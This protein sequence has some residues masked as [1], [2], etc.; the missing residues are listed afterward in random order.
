MFHFKHFMAPVLQRMRICY[1]SLCI[2]NYSEVWTVGLNKTSIL[3]VFLDN[4]N[5]ISFYK[6]I[7]QSHDESIMTHCLFLFGC[8]VE[9]GHWFS[10]SWA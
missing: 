4:F 8:A 6:I 5:N 9:P 1:L 10:L 2:F 7:N 3:H